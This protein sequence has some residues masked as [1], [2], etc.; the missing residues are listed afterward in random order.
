MTSSRRRN[1]GGPSL[2]REFSKEKFKLTFENCIVIGTG[3]DLLK[4]SEKAG[5]Y[6]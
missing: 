1:T 2:V 5:Q 6:G 3:I 4:S